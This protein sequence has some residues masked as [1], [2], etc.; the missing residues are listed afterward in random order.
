M[1]PKTYIYSKP[2]F[3]RLILSGF[4]FTE[5]RKKLSFGNKNENKRGNLSVLVIPRYKPAIPKVKEL[6]RKT[7]TSIPA[8]P[9]R[10]F[11]IRNRNLIL[12]SN[13]P[14]FRLRSHSDSCGNT[15]PALS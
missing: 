8:Q 4:H 1:Q 7:Y 13:R 12:T 5:K 2:A 9:Y 10:M 3:F 15:Q 6:C 14:Y 11:L